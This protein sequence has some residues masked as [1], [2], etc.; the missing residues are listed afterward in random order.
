MLFAWIEKEITLEEKKEGVEE[1]L[2]KI[3]EKNQKEEEG[4]LGLMACFNSSQGEEGRGEER[5]EK[6]RKREFLLILSISQIFNF[7]E[8]RDPQGVYL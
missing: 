8:K 1:I 2:K 6:K 5:E 7:M 3:K 4:Y